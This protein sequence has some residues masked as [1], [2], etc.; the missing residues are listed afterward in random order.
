MS[1][2]WKILYFAEKEDLPSEIEIFINSKDERNQAKI[3][4]WLDKLAELGPNLPRPYADLLIDGIHELRI[5]LSGS[6][7]RILYFFCYK[8]YIILTNQF[9][10]NTDK[11]PNSEI[12]KAIKR[13]ESFLQK[14]TEK[15][16][17]ELNL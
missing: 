17:K 6:Q 8:D 11:V 2:K 7:I 16:L 9:V 1:K 15:I 14:Y 5:K 4:A 3:F 12:N 10:K 13:R